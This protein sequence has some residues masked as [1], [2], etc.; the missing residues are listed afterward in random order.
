MA[1]GSAR[2]GQQ[3]E[4][5][6][7]CRR[8]VRAAERY[9]PPSSPP[10]R[11]LNEVHAGGD[12]D[13]HA[14]ASRLLARAWRAFPGLTGAPLGECKRLAARVLAGTPDCDSASWPQ[15]DG[16]SSGSDSDPVAAVLP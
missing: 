10:F 3:G 2:E 5:G 16:Q 15:H 6:T 9:H 12:A 13:E 14:K 4:F 11:C 8:A 7:T 1:V